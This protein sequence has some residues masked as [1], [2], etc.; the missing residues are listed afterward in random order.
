MKVNFKTAGSPNKIRNSAAPM[1]MI[2]GFGKRNSLLEVKA[3]A[4][5]PDRLRQSMRA[6]L[7]QNQNAQASLR[8]TITRAEK[9]FKIGETTE[10]GDVIIE[11]ERLKNTVEILN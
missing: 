10:A 5:S 2:K 1:S 9:S 4:A 7:A 8:N 3:A 11:N 6:S